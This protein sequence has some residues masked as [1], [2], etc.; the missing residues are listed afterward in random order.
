MQTV[1]QKIGTEYTDWV[2]KDDDRRGASW[3]FISAPT[4]SGKTYFIFETL[5]KYLVSESKSMLYLV[6]RSILKK[7]LKDKVK[8]MSP[9]I[10]NHIHIKLYQ[11][12]EK[13]IKLNEYNAGKSNDCTYDNMKQYMKYDCVVCDE[14][15]YFLSDSNY[16]TD[17]ALSFRWIYDY[18]SKKI[19]IFMSATIDDIKLYIKAYDIIRAKKQEQYKY[20]YIGFDIL[21][22]IV[23][24]ANSFKELY[25]GMIF[26][27][28][29]YVEY[30]IE[31]NY[32]YLNITIINKENIVDCISNSAKTEKWLIFVDNI[33]F[34][35]H[36]KKKFKDN[37]VAFLTSENKN[38][39]EELKVVHDMATKEKTN[40]RIVIATSVIDN[41]INI[42]DI[43]LRNV[44]IMADTEMEFIQ[45]LGRK[46]K[47]GSTLKLYICKYDKQHFERRLRN[48]KEKINIANE[49]IS[50]IIEKKDNYEYAYNENMAIEHLHIKYMRELAENTTKL[51]YARSIF[52]VY[53]GVLYL[54]LLAYNNLRRLREYYEYVIE[55][56]DTNGESAYVK[57]QLAWLGMEG[58]AEDIIN[59]SNVSIEE[60]S[61]KKVADAFESKLGQAMSSDEWK[62]FSY[63]LRDDLRRLLDSLEIDEELKKVYNAVGKSDR[64][65]SNKSM[66]YLSE[67]F[68]LPYRLKAK[69][70]MYT[71]ERI[72]EDK[73]IK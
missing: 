6:N 69:D 27:K 7:Q 33:K 68:D 56:F 30:D 44:V 8:D 65:I 64:G 9:E 32:D 29:N 71:I 19:K 23:E 16:N 70:G 58:K 39:E 5:L 40:K 48:T 18:F 13:E 22:K 66:K 41:G 31:R 37:A 11:E 59:N 35:N 50:Y 60:R 62:G 73:S 51:N 10:S 28:H 17:T 20:N 36:L 57:I 47:D 34:G 53:G 42:K 72:M 46:R 49:Y 26:D 21:N 24:D 55:Q 38:D 61:L 54:N 45:M 15:H 67:H 12:I 63:S 52:N 3:I 2:M 14:C 43:E 25:R 4:G 1:T